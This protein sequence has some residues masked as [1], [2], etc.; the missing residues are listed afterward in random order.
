MSKVQ[1]FNFIIDN[2]IPTKKKLRKPK[3]TVQNYRNFDLKTISNLFEN[4][5][6]RYIIP[7]KSSN[8]FSK[9]HVSIT[10]MKNNRNNSKKNIA[11]RYS[12]DKPFL[13][14]K[15]NTT[16]IYNYNFIGAINEKNINS[17]I[18]SSPNRDFINYNDNHIILDKSNDFDL[19]YNKIP[20]IN[21]NFTRNITEK[22]HKIKKFFGDSRNEGKSSEYDYYTY[23]S[24][25][26][27]NGNL[28]KRNTSEIIN[29]NSNIIYGNNKVAK[30]YL[31]NELSPIQNKQNKSIENIENIK[32][33]KVNQVIKTNC[34]PYNNLI[35][36]SPRN[37]YTD[38]RSLSPNQQISYSFYKNKTRKTFVYS[39]SPEIT[40]YNN[41][42]INEKDPNFKSYNF[43][44]H[45]YKFVSHSNKKIIVTT[46]Y[47]N[48]NI[49]L[50][51]STNA[52]K[53]TVAKIIKNKIPKKIKKKTNSKKEL[54]NIFCDNNQKINKKN[55]KNKK[56][57][58]PVSKVNEEN[59]I[60]S[61]KPK[62][63]ENEIDSITMQSMN[64]A[65]LLE[66]AKYIMEN[67]KEDSID[68][69]LVE[70]LLSNKKNKGN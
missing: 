6:I 30:I 51:L 10:K 7:S 4:R 65:K 1:S 20:K 50:K 40:S 37:T 17:V 41:I 18:Y 39:K 70:N 2:Q 11:S 57:I 52:N 31:V 15:Q 54:N 61:P 64:D 53:K 66:L 59:I 3:Q 24:I 44:N 29:N 38:T 16:N 23:L 48:N 5:N 19:K 47:G 25:Y 13:N 21:C 8:I 60:N 42:K 62:N 45:N 56:T 28:H 69:N 55:A 67:N 49:N 22:A 35:N 46:P 12:T 43:D 27:N 33:K 63:N 68:K 32:Y 9:R 58:I 34:F 36:V 14:I 26:N